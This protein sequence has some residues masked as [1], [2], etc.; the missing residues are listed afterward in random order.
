[1]V[2]EGQAAPVGL[3]DTSVVIVLG[4][5]DPALLPIEPVISAV[6]L[7]ELSAGPLV[8][9]TDEERTTRQSRLQQTETDFDPV[10]FDAVAAR[11]FGAVSSSL[12][13]SGCKVSAR[14]YD[15]MIAAT[16]LAHR[17]P[18]YTCNPDDVRDIDGL[19][20]V[21]VRIPGP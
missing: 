18:L 15:A 9:R 21:A 12:R 17:L 6:T 4:R 16:A 7:A 5:I 1:M 11:A 8:A 20:V 10:P 19:E 3:L 2:T 14:T 13:S